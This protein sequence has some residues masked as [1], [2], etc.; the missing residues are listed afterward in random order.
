[1]SAR[2]QR[3]IGLVLAFVGLVLVVTPLLLPSLQ[4]WRRAR[5]AERLQ[6]EAAGLH[7]QLTDWHS[8]LRNGLIDWGSE[9]LASEAELAAKPFV[10]EI[11]AISLKTLVAVGSSAETLE[12]GAGWRTSSAYPGQ[13]GTCVVLGHRNAYAAPFK[14]LDA[15]KPGDDLACHTALG[16]FRYAVEEVKFVSYEAVPLA[17]PGADARIALITCHPYLRPTGSLVVLGRMAA[18]TR[19]SPASGAETGRAEMAT[20]PPAPWANPLLHQVWVPPVAEG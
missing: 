19:R 8:W 1:V 20:G 2:T 6:R 13:P 11:P 17:F 15:L 10:L 9:D 7:R 3:V 12:K 16:K 5:Q 14:K 18:A 4:G